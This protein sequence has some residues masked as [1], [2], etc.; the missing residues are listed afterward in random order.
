MVLRDALI[1]YSNSKYPLL[2]T[3]ELLMQDLGPKIQVNKL[4][5]I[6]FLCYI[7]S[8]GSRGGSLTCCFPAW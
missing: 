1:G 5:N 4:V 7:F 2:F 3:S 8:V 6:I